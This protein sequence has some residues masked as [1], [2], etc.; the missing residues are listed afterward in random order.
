MIQNRVLAKQLRMGRRLKW[1]SGHVG[2]YAKMSKMGE[3]AGIK[4]GAVPIPS[5]KTAIAGQKIG[6]KVYADVSKAYKEELK[7][8]KGKGKGGALKMSSSDIA[9]LKE[10]QDAL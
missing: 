6:D 8:A 3:S 10:K 9:A 2:K 4:T 7:G 5:Q 1:L